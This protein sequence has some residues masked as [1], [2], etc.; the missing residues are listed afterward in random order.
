MIPHTA[1]PPR[2]LPPLLLYGVILVVLAVAAAGALVAVT[3]AGAADPGA[4]DRPSLPGT[5][6]QVPTSFGTMIVGRV[7]NV[8][9]LTA[10]DTAGVTHGIQ[11]LVTSENAQVEASLY[12]SNAGETTQPYS[13]TDFS[14]RRLRPDGRTRV[15]P[16]VKSDVGP[17]VLQPRATVE[18]RLGF[19]VPRDGSRLVLAYDDPGADRPILI[20]LGR[21]NANGHDSG[22][23]HAAHHHP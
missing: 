8:N 22:A 18:L 17:G 16:T 20:R 12:L 1:A 23:G 13:P 15:V 7:T 2:A 21:V 3:G 19:V 4:A 10:K 9:G 5:D 11:N 14:V 6:Q